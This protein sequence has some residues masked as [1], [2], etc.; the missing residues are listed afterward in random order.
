MNNYFTKY[1]DEKTFIISDP[2]T[3][4]KYIF[5]TFDKNKEMISRYYIRKQNNYKKNEKNDYFPSCQNTWGCKSIDKILNK[6]MNY[7]IKNNYSILAFHAAN[8]FPEE[9]DD[10][11]FRGFKLFNEDNYL[12]QKLNKLAVHGFAPETILALRDLSLVKKETRKNKIYFFHSVNTIYNKDGIEELLSC[13]GGEI[14]YFGLRKQKDLLEKIK[15]IGKPYIVVCRMPICK[16]KVVVGNI[17]TM[18]SNWHNETYQDINPNSNI[19]NINDVEILDVVEFDTILCQI[20][21]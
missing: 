2:K 8:L 4:P 18:L 5:E 16:S 21:E 20:K 14:T 10:I 13:W 7:L 19:R 9:R 1:L 3:Y 6:I 15:N 12:E 11:L 17:E